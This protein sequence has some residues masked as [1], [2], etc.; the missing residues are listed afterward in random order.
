ML[1]GEINVPTT[2]LNEQTWPYVARFYLQS[3]QRA[4]HPAEP[5]VEQLCIVRLCRDVKAV[6]VAPVRSRGDG[7]SCLVDSQILTYRS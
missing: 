3:S 1:S 2:V 6:P 7:E 4:A 5:R